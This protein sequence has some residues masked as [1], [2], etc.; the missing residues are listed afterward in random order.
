MDAWTACLIPKSP[1]TSS[2]SEMSNQCDEW[3]R[4][5]ERKKNAK[6]VSNNRKV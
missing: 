6:V 5:M 4:Q 2:N 3:S 1:S